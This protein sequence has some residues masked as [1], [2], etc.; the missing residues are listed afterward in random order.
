MAKL[1]HGVE[2]EL[3]KYMDSLQFRMQEAINTAQGL[4]P[5]IDSLRARLA[6]IEDD[7]AAALE[8]SLRKSDDMLNN[9]LR[10]AAN[11]QQMIA[12]MVQAVLE[13]TSHV[14]AAQERSIQLAQQNNDDSSLWAIGLANAA[15]S[16]TTLN[17][18]LVCTI[19][20]TY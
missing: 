6:N 11:L 17:N 19:V 13:G 3:Q 7:V 14:A 12:V 5:Q 18:E 16:A 10:G 20:S 9:N 4:E 1:A 8:G 2:I 15:S